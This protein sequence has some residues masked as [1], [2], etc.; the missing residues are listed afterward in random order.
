MTNT[1]QKADKNQSMD[2]CK[3]IAALFV[4]SIHVP[5]PGAFGSA[6]ELIG[7]FAVPMFL[8][9]TGYFNYGANAATIARRMVHI[10]KL[11]VFACVFYMFSN[12]LNAYFMGVPVWDFLSWDQVTPGLPVLMRWFILHWNPFSEHLWYLSAVTLC[13]FLL[14]LY[15]SAFGEKPVNYRAVYLI[16]LFAGGL[17]I[18]TAIL[19][20][21]TGN[22]VDCH[23]YRNGW[24]T[25]IALFS[26]GLFLHEYQ[27]TLFC[28][29]HLKNW[30]LV[31]QILFGFVL[32]LCEWR[33]GIA[34]EVTLG[35]LI[36]LP[37]LMTLLI[38]HPRLPVKSPVLITLIS[39]FR[40]LST[41]IYI[42]HCA[43]IWVYDRFFQPL[44]YSFMGDAE[45]L[46]RP[47]GVLILTL[48]G[49][50]IWDQVDIYRSKKRK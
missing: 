43:F 14:W 29:L 19:L 18:Y 4:L 27:D 2:L 12:S 8:A 36:L 13:Y 46:F 35:H 24:F 16:G 38:R 17:L 37:A 32:A 40:S 45:A 15:V 1:I 30:H 11:T 28:N 39:R 7:R 33:C 44:F 21:W 26:L 5:F 34:G 47:F 3:M 50:V 25:G 10:V 6:I 31:V 9:I 23:V 42:L 48:I 22:G 20:P 49:A 41:A